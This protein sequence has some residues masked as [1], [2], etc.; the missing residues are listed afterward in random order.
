MI[1]SVLCCVLH[2]VSYYYIITLSYSS[3]FGL[4]D[5]LH[6]FFMM[7]CDCDDTICFGFALSVFSNIQNLIIPLS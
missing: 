5:V 2:C 6:F 1:Y 3:W 7:R 4:L